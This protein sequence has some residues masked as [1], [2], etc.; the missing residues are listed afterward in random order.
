MRFSSLILFTFTLLI[1]CSDNS[2]IMGFDI[3]K[4]KA[5]ES[6]WKSKIDQQIQKS[7]DVNEL[8]DWFEQEGVDMRFD[9]PLFRIVELEKIPS[10]EDPKCYT[11]V[12]FSITELKEQR[13]ES[14][15]VSSMG[16]C[17]DQTGA[18]K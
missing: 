8:S 5:V 9:L 2:N 12:S 10:L 3:E 1:A 18:F 11:S 4:T 14:Y 7:N 6:E 16:V 13:I 17:R 15:R